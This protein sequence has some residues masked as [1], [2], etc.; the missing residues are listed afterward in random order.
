[1][2]MFA[3]HFGTSLPFKCT[4]CSACW[5]AIPCSSIRFA[6]QFSGRRDRHRNFQPVVTSVYHTASCFCKTERNRDNS[7]RGE[8]TACLIALN[9]DSAVFICYTHAEMDHHRP[10][11][12]LTARSDALIP[13]DALCPHTP[14]S[15]NPSPS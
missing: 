10:L 3:S 1:M 11:S 2:E 4:H 15:G 6:R 12:I 9:L 14:V 5:A 13:D 8:G 7:P